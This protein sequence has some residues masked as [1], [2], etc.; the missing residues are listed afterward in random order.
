[1]TPRVE[2]PRIVDE[3]AGESQRTRKKLAATRVRHWQKLTKDVNAFPPNQLHASSLRTHPDFGVSYRKRDEGGLMLDVARHATGKNRNHRWSRSDLDLVIRDRASLILFSGRDGKNT[4][5]PPH[6]SDKEVL[7]VS[8]RE[9]LSRVFPWSV[10]PSV[11]ACTLV[12]SN[13]LTTSTDSLACCAGATK[14]LS[15]LPVSKTCVAHLS[16]IVIEHTR[17]PLW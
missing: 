11:S 3:D 12:H 2:K 7:F 9:H 1:M 15:D 6:G 8:Q 10:S 5:V 14:Q 4:S 13:S 16:G 17:V